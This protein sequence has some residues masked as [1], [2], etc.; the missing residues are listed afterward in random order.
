MEEKKL[1]LLDAYALIFRAYYALIRNPRYTSQGLNTSAIFG[2]VNTLQD[3]LKRE[4]PS[5]IAICFDPKGGTFRHEM[6]AEYKA[7]REETPEDIRKAVPYIKRIAQAYNI[8]VLE[9]PGYEADDVIG[10]LSLLAEK[11]GFTTYMVTGDKDFGQLVSQS[12]KIYR[13]NSGGGYEIMGEKEVCDKFGI[14]RADQVIDMLALM[15]DKV[16][17]IPGCPG[18]GE[19]TA[20]KLIRQFGSVEN[21]INNTS[22]LKGAL[23]KKVEENIEKIKFSKF[24]ATIC[25]E[26]PIEL[27]EQELKRQ[28]IN[29]EALRQLFKE[30]EFRNFATRIIDQNEGNIGLDGAPAPEVKA[31]ATSA[32]ASAPTA[33]KTAQVKKKQSAQMSLFGDDD[34]EEE[35]TEN[36]PTETPVIEQPVEIVYTHIT[37]ADELR[38]R[39][40]DAMKLDAVGCELVADGDD[41]MTA[42]LVGIAVAV[43]R[44]SAFYADASLVELLKPLLESASVTLVSGDV[45]R[46]MVVLRRRGINLA[47]PYF[48][49][50]VAHYL[51]Q[52]ER[53]HATARLAEEI[54]GVACTT[55]EALL[56]AKGRNR[57][58]FV[59][60]SSDAITSYACQLADMALALRK[61][62][63]AS[64]DADSL[65]S[66]LTDIEL[67]LIEVLADMEHTGARVDVRA[68]TDYSVV[69]TERMNSLEQECFE[70]A[71][72]Q[73]NTASPMK[74]GEILFDKL[75]IDDKAKK[76]KSGQYS[77]TEE[78]LM[79][80]RDR[81]PLVDKIL[82]LRG[83][84]KLLSTYVNAL[85]ELINPETGRI[86]TTYNQTVTATGRLSSTNPNLQNIPVRTD[87][88]REIRRAFIPADGNLFFSADYSQIELRLVADLSGD[89]TMVDAF[90]NNLDIHAITAAKIYHEPLEKVTPD[91]RR[92]AKTANFG[93]LYGISAFGLSE[94][95]QIPRAESKMLIDGYFATF[96]GVRDYIERSV[97]QAKEKGY[98]TTL[99]GR[100][101]MLPDI[102]SRNAVVRSF[103]ERNAVNAPIQ[104]TAADIIKIAMVSIF[105]KMKQEGLR[106]KMILQVH[107]ELN[108]DVVPAEAERVQQIAVEC[109]QNAYHG[110][111]PLTASH[112]IATNWLDAH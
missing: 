71:G 108:F 11:K 79:H 24:L 102:N 15:G 99:F 96:P 2:F 1:V 5:H 63:I 64:I 38:R 41:A 14:E 109:M 83:I 112:A 69:L 45:K 35:N 72:E 31:S 100:R 111:V 62:L 75:K 97:T 44:G 3:L 20:A 110:N 56:G 32:A 103:S 88:G 107:D 22:E 82:E 67:P 57:K 18:V 89:P 37:D 104:G 80:L 9:V 49:T 85:P 90:R 101:R 6:Y 77:T 59:E 66:L 25:R 92:K 28:P 91:Q 29:A 17:N 10:T 53:P 55:D 4:N 51:L 42:S 98:V 7:G 61:P 78:V 40:A 39:V 58:R 105:N 68:L 52:P 16:D 84:R 47:A 93:I 65:T 36:I 46:A 60:V 48:D 70:L 86:H 30:L 33:A 54:L 73:F 12:V 21:L 13:P 74:V 76:T 43:K 87:D 81:H 94:R 95:L 8:A 106:S 23:K 50:A 26:V 34:E 19:V 27:N